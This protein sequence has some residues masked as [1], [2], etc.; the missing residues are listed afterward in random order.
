MPILCQVAR[1]E[2]R[3]TGYGIMNFVSMVCGGAADW[4]F[5][6]MT[7]RKVPLNVIFSIFAAF[8]IVSIALVL[9]IRP[10]DHRG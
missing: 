6:A 4:G 10:R 5:G 2:A 7:D 8:C 3:A 9:L 1:P